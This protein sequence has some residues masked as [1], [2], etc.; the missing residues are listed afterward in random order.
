MKDQDLMKD[1]GSTVDFC[2]LEGLVPRVTGQEWII[3]GRK[4]PT[5]N[6]AAM[7]SCLAAGTRGPEGRVKGPLQRGLPSPKASTVSTSRVGSCAREFPT[8][9]TC[10]KF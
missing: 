2:R 9:P 1:Q 5:E 10:Q 4:T 6:P 3:R 8:Y 7:S